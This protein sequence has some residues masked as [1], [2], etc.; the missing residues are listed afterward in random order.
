MDD[1]S[2]ALV[3]AVAGCLGATASL[4]LFYPLDLLRTLRQAEAA[5][6]QARERSSHTA[7]SDSSSSLA[8][9]GLSSDL[10]RLSLKRLYRG[11]TSTVCT[12]SVSFFVYFFAFRFLQRRVPVTVG[13]SA[14]RDVFVA[15][16]AGCI[17]VR[18]A[19]VVVVVTCTHAWVDGGYQ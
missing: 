18:S 3:H 8:S 6:A 5:S 12:Q 10:R 19:V 17:N 13:G 7:T 15:A 4:G 11:F 1:D 9:S 16:A 2:N 14:S